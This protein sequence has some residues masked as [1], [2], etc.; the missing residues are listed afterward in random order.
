MSLTYGADAA[1]YSPSHGSV[2]TLIIGGSVRQMR[3]TLTEFNKYVVAASQETISSNTCGESRGL[4]APAPV[5]ALLAF[6]AGGDGT[7]RLEEPNG[8]HSQPTQEF[9]I[10]P[11]IPSRHSLFDELMAR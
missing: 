2:A 11:P 4:V 1:S 3:G 8:K 7:E 10:R 9:A 5:N 6:S